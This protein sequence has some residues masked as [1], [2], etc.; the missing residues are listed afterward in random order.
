MS[1]PR[2]RSSEITSES[3]YHDRRAFL[4]R[5]GLTAAAAVAATFLPVTGAASTQADAIR[6]KT[7]AGPY[8]SDESPNSWEDV[9]TYNNFYEFGTDKEDPHQ[10]SRHKQ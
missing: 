10:N 3:I 6:L 9:T 7:T 8:S 5:A 4:Q 1:Q 2:I